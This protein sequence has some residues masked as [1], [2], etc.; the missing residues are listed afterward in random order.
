MTRVECKFKQYG[1]LRIMWKIQLVLIITKRKTTTC[2]ALKLLV[3][4]DA[5]TPLIR[6]LV[7]DVALAGWNPNKEALFDL[8]N[9]VFIRK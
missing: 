8:N 2:F 5:A 4:I 3:S 6:I 7:R 9:L 1:W